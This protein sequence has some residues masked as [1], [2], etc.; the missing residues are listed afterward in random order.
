M[1]TDIGGYGYGD[2]ALELELLVEAGMTPARRSKSAPAARPSAWDVDDG[3][4][5]RG[6]QGA[7]LLVVD[8]DPARRHRRAPPGEH[9]ALVMKA[10]AAVTGPLAA[11]LDGRRR[12]EGGARVVWS[13]QAA[14]AHD[15]VDLQDD[16]DGERHQHGG[17]RRH[18]RVAVVLD[19]LE[20]ADGQRHHALEAR[21]HAACPRSPSVDRAR[22]VERTRRGGHRRAP[23]PAGARYV[24]SARGS[25]MSSA[26]V[27]RDGAPR[28]PS[29]ARWSHERVSFISAARPAA[30]Y[31]H[32]AAAIR[33]TARIAAWGGL[34]IAMNPSTSY[35]PRLLI[36]NPPPVMSAG[37]AAGLGATDQGLALGD[38]LGQPEAVRVMDHGNDQPVVDGHGEADVD[39][40]LPPRSRR[41]LPGRVHAGMLSDG[42]GDQLHQGGRYRRR[43]RRCA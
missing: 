15:A 33:P 13:E 31:G 21:R 26:R 27:A 2:T 18:Q 12:P 14:E 36:V 6:R 38:H 17:D 8:G 19:V 29:S 42:G 37:R 7:D 11:G 34:M 28:A 35:I 23:A 24:S 40:G 4:H 16:R 20:D 1:G 30:L 32:D 39:V 3:R 10:G 25:S 43:V 9:R 5:A 22:A 41:P